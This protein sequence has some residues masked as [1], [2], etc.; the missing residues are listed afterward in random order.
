MIKMQKK[1]CRLVAT[2]ALSFLANHGIHAQSVIVQP[3]LNPEELANVITGNGVQ[4][5]NPSLTCA[6]GASGTYDIQSVTGFPEGSGVVLSTGNIADVRGPNTSES[7]TTEFDTPGDPFLTSII[8]NTT[9]DG[10]ALE[11]DVVPVGDTLRFNFTFAS[12]EYSEYVGTPFNDAFGFFISGPGITG[13]PEFDG[14]ENIALIPNTSTPVEINSINNGNPDIGF[15][16][17]NPEFFNAN[18]L[19]F[20]NIIQYDGWTVDVFA[21]KIVQPCD[22]FH[23]KLVIADGADR[24][25]DSA[26]FIEEIQSNNV[27]LTSSTIGGIENMIEGCNDGTVTFTREPV[28]EEEFI[29]TYFIG[30]T[31][32]NGTDYPLIGDDPDPNEPKFITIPANQATASVDISPFD[33]GLTEGDETVIFYVGNPNCAGTI[34]DSLIFTIQD[35]LNLAINPPLAFVCLGDSLTFDVQSEATSYTWT[36]GDF[37]D[38]STIQNPTTTPTANITYTLNTGVA[39]CTST[40][41]S[42]IFV[43]DVQLSV[44]TTDILC[45]GDAT[46]EIDLTVVGAQSPIDYE[47]VG[48]N[49]FTSDSEDITDLEVGTYAVL[50]TDRDGCTESLE[51]EIIENPI[52]EVTLDSP[53]YTGGDNISCFSATDGE[54]TATVSGGVPPY[55]FQWDDPAAQTG[56]TATGLSAGTYTV[57]ITD[58]NNC[59]IEESITLIQ[60]EIITGDLI[61]RINVLCTGDESG[62]AIIEAIGGNAPYTYL[63]NTVPPQSGPELTGV[64]A[65]FY[66]VSIT[67][68]NGCLGSLEIEIE[69]PDSELSGNVNTTD[70]ICNGD[71][72]GSATANI[73]GGTTPYTYEW[74]SDPGLNQPNISG[75]SAGS[76]VLTVTDDNGCV[77]TIP[78]NIAEP[79]V[80]ELQ[81]VSVIDVDCAG[82]NT[83][84][85]T[86]IATGGTTPY[87]YEWNTDP[88]TAGPSI[89]NVP[90]GLYQVIVTDANACTDTLEIEII[91][92]DPIQIN[93]VDQV[94]LPCFGDETGSLEVE[95]TGGTAPLQYSWSTVPPT[96]GTTLNNLG[97]GSY[98]VTVTDDNG[99]QATETYTITA[100]DQIEIQVDAIQNVLCNGENTGS[101]TVSATGGVPEYSFEWNDPNT[102]SGAT[103]DNLAAGT[104]TVTVTDQNNCTGQLEITIT[105]PSSPLG[106]N[107]I[108]VQDVL[109]FGDGDG[110]ATVE[111]TGGS[112]SYLYQWDDPDGQQTP[113]ASGLDPG[114]YTVTIT[115]NNG[116]PISV[117]L[118]ITIDGPTDPLVL[119]LTPSSFGGG[120][121][122]ACADDSTATIDL[123][124]T[125]GTAPYDVLWNLPGLETSTDEDLSDLA[126]GTYSVTV[127][128]TNGCEED[129]E[130]TLTAPQP[131][132]IEFTTTP[133]LCFGIP[134]GSIEISIEG[135][136]PSYDVSWSGPNGFMS[137]DLLLEDL[138]GGIYNLTIEDSNGC[139]YEDAIT[140]V[141]PDDL[142]I[143]VDSLSDFNGFNTT[144][145][146]T[147]DGA[148]YTSSNGGTTPY[149][150]QWN[151]T[152][153]PNISDQEDL[154]GV[155]GGTYELVLTD[156]NGCVQNEFVE[157]TSPDTLEIALN[158]SIYGNGFNISCFGEMDGSVQ[159]NVSGGTPDYTFTWTGTDG[160]GPTNDNPI[161]NL[162]AGEYNVL[163]EDANG[164]TMENSIV[165]NEPDTF[166]IALESP[167]VNGNN[168]SCNGGNDGSIN[169]ITTGGENPFDISWTGPDGF[170][171][172]DADLF[173]L[174]AGEY[175]LTIT[176][177]N[178]CVKQEC[179]T[180]TEPDPINNE[181]TLSV[182]V[183]GTNSSCSDSNDGSI[184]TLTTGGTAPYS[185]SW[186][187]PGNF[188]SSFADIFGLAPG[189]YCL[190]V[191]DANGCEETECVTITAP[192]PIE[193]ILEEYIPSGCSGDNTASIDVTV[194]GGDPAYTY[195]WTG[196]NGFTASTQDI[197]NLEPGT[198][199]LLLTDVTNCTSENCFEVVDPLPLSYAFQ[200]SSFAGGFEIDCTGN[201]SGS[202]SIAPSGGS[203][204]YTVNWT[205]PDGFTSNDLNINDLIA[206]TYCFELMDA[207]NC[208]LNDCID[209]EEPS[210][211]VADPIITLP[212]C[213][214]GTP[215]TIDLNVSGGVPPYEF[216]W[217]QGDDTEI[218]QVGEG[219]YSVIISDA[220]DCFTEE[221]FN[222]ILPSSVIVIPES[223]TTNGF[224]IACNGDF[225]GE[226]NITVFGGDGNLSAEWTGPDGFSSADA[227]ISGLQAGTYCV[228]V[229]D[230][231]GCEGDTCITLTEP[232]ALEA[233]LTAE[234]VSCNG[235]TDGSISAQ[236]IGGVPIYSIS[237]TGP[238]GF[239]ANGPEISGLEIGTYCADIIDFNGCTTLQCIDVNEPDEITINLSSPEIDGVNILCFGD[240]T[241][242]IA[243]EILGG[244]APYSFS[245]TGPSGYASSEEDIGNLF[246]GEYCLTVTDA[247]NCEATT[248]ITLTEGPELIFTFD[249]FEYPNGFNVSCNGE[250]DGSLEASIAG[251]GPPPYAF[252]WTGPNGF[253][254][255][256]L[257][258]SDLCAGTYNL[259]VT[260][261][262]G[263]IQSASITLSQ[264]DPINIDLESPVFGGGLEISCFGENTGIINT[265]VT[266]GIGELFYTWTGP[267]GFTSDQANLE[268]LVAGTYTLEVMDEAGCSNTAEI[269]LNEPEEALTASA[270]AFE[271]PS[272]DN[273]SCLGANDGSIESNAS[274][275]TTPY[276]YNWNGPN[277]FT[278]NN[279]NIDDLEPGDYTLVVED[280]N[281]CVFTI[282]ITITEPMTQVDTD[283]T[284]DQ[285][286][287][288]NGDETGSLSVS[289]DGGSPGYTIVWVGPDNFTSTEFTISDL[290]AGTYTYVVE[291]IN[292]CSSSGAH[293]FVNPSALVLN[294]DVI[295]AECETPTGAIDLTVSG[296]TPEYTYLWDDENATTDQD[297]IG[298]GAGDYSVIITDQN[299]CSETASFTVETFSSLELE[300]SISNLLCNGDSTGSINISITQ[301]SEPV[302]FAW[303]GPDGFSASGPGIENLIAGDYELVAE[304]ANGCETVA[305]Y[306]VSQPDSLIIE[307]LFS[308]FYSNGFNLSGF[309]S[310]DGIIEEPEVVGGTEPYDYAWSSD[311]GYQ[312][313]SPLNQLNLAAGTYA[314][315]VVDQNMCS[316]TAFITLT[317][318][319]PLELPNGVSPN[320]DGFNDALIVRGLEDYPQNK[321]IVFN[322]WGNEVYEES[323]Y[324]NSSPWFGVNNS[325]EAIPEGTYFVVV[326]LEG[327]DALRGYLELRR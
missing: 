234:N 89:S 75:L 220:N 9:F 136:V 105:E 282:N 251:G 59:V 99:C 134:S 197:S 269:T 303:S 138:E 319:I 71:G 32:T 17:V 272:G 126:P 235:F 94:N 30:G 194:I 292:G 309:E 34:Q 233:L 276:S 149:T 97:E 297:L 190:T 310:G 222:I 324:R 228:T 2:V 147:E 175:C 49:G 193:I 107:I 246:A 96:P 153:E 306:T 102:Q 164:C 143:T 268:E 53:T 168:I 180:L 66:T 270:T 141:Q 36:P 285:D 195:S 286:I 289:A 275:G 239:T 160:Y 166:G 62:S 124:I 1:L 52:L 33:D 29:V 103:A 61:E 67:D 262:D 192:P 60:P 201:N 84:S 50:V 24:E 20:S 253:S 8:G 129:A 98:T 146:D 119:T 281:S 317:Q 244:T 72:S 243:A 95:A 113:T 186:F 203:S 15:P 154:E 91:E 261:D 117:E 267:N 308:P 150:F 100:P 13:E 219:T 230:D 207:N 47:W 250:C 79:L 21:E 247:N 238:N 273:I 112:G 189:E 109:C 6:D 108:N 200:T 191:T 325:G 139:I 152:G 57:T 39:S 44:N 188:T 327:A 58:A 229:T 224:N 157:L 240:N 212:D 14:A 177:A 301:G 104:Y 85:A 77:L 78:F 19:G 92:P 236:I 45:G 73:T 25:W 198:Y 155:A 165:L 264:P 290:P 10:C 169:L 209:L 80:L 254:S 81:A 206:G 12:E 225:T 187:G 184:T 216:N 125:G 41:I 245:W 314:L 68:V 323:N 7:T 183:N 151:T 211:L 226:I 304:D 279:A 266:G 128:D 242:S 51:I 237:W 115:D 227:N 283:I 231:L 299:G 318:P 16:A 83:G 65:G 202:I 178:N 271:F 284:V 258:L 48:P 288:C 93:L 133:S 252:E 159:A 174:S 173:D 277:D 241:G 163:V 311:N 69:E 142:T 280:A 199:C 38:D 42:E 296:G 326:E 64:G 37:L 123:D 137:S 54:A 316:D 22:T 31:A 158:P 121:N 214:D 257:I 204:P 23:L 130:I 86:V 18:P 140:V 322:R 171:S 196:P 161:E 114:T 5:L 144:C 312:S 259:S 28:T 232:E 278:S 305:S 217:S 320:G 223:P 131:I 145:W 135:G 4:L 298:V 167:L 321:L 3:G 294:G 55:S 40:A 300:A 287:L 63:W 256:D 156:A 26:V 11:F 127:T 182:F 307:P 116:C 56:Q 162:P 101:V 302:D 210:P 221:D 315:V 172:T 255:S 43:T 74:S 179:I 170:T 110:Q 132:S 118:I 274:G 27:S 313:D 293:T 148:I 263:C 46:G 35:S 122:V 248:C 218:V 76:Y 87:T 120:F 215:A 185:F 213:G 249:L 260:D 181:F 106:G 70:L 88:V 176:D 90:A 111:G 291:D 295:D 265:T 82:Q 208:V 205:G